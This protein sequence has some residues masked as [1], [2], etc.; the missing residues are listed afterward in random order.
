MTA[1]EADLGR[2]H[3]SGF[4]SVSSVSL[5]KKARVATREKERER[6]ALLLYARRVLED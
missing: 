3:I 4:F 1:A 2:V 6:L 5:E